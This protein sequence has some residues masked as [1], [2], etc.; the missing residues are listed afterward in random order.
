MSMEIIN[1]SYSHYKT[2][3]AEKLEEERPLD[4]AEKTEKTQRGQTDE[5]SSDKIPVPQDEYI[6]S[7]KSGDK[8]SGLYRIGQDEDGRKKVFFDDP[9]RSDS[10]DGNEQPKVKPD[11]PEKPEEKK[12]TGNTD[13]VDREIR[14]LKEKKK[15]LEQ[16]IKEA[17]GDDKK[18]KELEKKLAQVENE[19]SQKD[20]DAYRRQ[21]STFTEQ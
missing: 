1:G 19:L 13:K 18:V 10:A 12:C 4:R 15:Q 5:K 16:Q 7:E 2:G 21:H 20:N 17:S 11:A 14:K 8:P 6:S 3:Y 9:K